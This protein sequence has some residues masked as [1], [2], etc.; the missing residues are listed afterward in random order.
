MYPMAA[1]GGTSVRET[2]ANTGAALSHA[3]R[4]IDRRRTSPP[5]P[6][7]MN[8]VL[9]GIEDF[10]IVREDTLRSPAFTDSSTGGLATFDCVI[11]NDAL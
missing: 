10:Q 7:R 8:L 6:S 5:R 1:T 2:P 9:H 4:E 11:A 3:M